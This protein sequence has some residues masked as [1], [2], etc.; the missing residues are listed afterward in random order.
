MIG[1]KKRFNKLHEYLLAKGIVLSK[2]TLSQHLKHLTE[3]KMVIRRVEEAQ[4][5]SYEVN[6]RRFGD[7]GENVKSVLAAARSI[8]KGKQAFDSA[9]PD[10]QTT[11][12]CEDMILRSLR[13]LKTRIE[14]QSKPSNWEKSLELSLLESP[15]FRIHEEWFL[16]KC[17]T[18]TGYSEEI[19]QRTSEMIVKIE[20]R[21]QCSS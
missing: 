12:V 2:P 1:E 16:A 6:H 7:L 21:K 9:S 4:I 14:L 10:E 19:L 3:K 20:T 18:D 8:D 13:Q 15:L 17:G 5:V 11:I